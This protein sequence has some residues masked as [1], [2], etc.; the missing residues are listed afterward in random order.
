MPPARASNFAAL[1]L[2]EM[3]QPNTFT[4]FQVLVKRKSGDGSMCLAVTPEGIAGLT[5]RNSADL[6]F[7]HGWSF[8]RSFLTPKNRDDCAGYTLPMNGK[9]FEFFFKFENATEQQIF[10]T[11]TVARACV[12]ACL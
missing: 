6:C 8:V 9:D 12:R 5:T 7:F 3:G 2:A 11:S 4:F 1:L 10:L